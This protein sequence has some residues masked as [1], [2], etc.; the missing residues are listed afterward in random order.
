MDGRST[1]ETTEFL[2]KWVGFKEPTWQAYETLPPVVLE[3]YRECQEEAKQRYEEDVEC[4]TLKENQHEPKLFHTAGN[5]FYVFSNG[6]ILY[7]KELFVAEGKSQVYQAL[8]EL[9]QIPGCEHVSQLPLAYDD[10]CHLVKFATNRQRGKTPRTKQMAVWLGELCR[11]DR[12]HYKNH[13]DAWCRQNMNPDKCNAKCASACS[14]KGKGK[15]KV[16]DGVATERAEE[17]FSWLSRYRFACRHMSCERFNFFLTR[18]MEMHNRK[19]YRD[20][21]QAKAKAEAVKHKAGAKCT[22]KSNTEAN[23]K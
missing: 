5:L 21:L 13:I 19:K 6:I 2:V 14:V 4:A 18:V 12:M 23:A 3:E 1:D 20:L 7:R 11:L 15:C 22:P 16:F 9:I 17:T 8:S 10:A